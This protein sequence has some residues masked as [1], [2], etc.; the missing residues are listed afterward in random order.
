M[1]LVIGYGNPLRGD[2]AAGWAAARLLEAENLPPHARVMALHQL[3]PDLAEPLSRVP[4]AVFID[5][6]AQLAP[7][8]LR[9]S[10]IQPLKAIPS[11]THH[12]LPST[13]LF[14]AEA[15]YG[16]APEAREFAIGAQD[17][18]H[19]E[20]MSEAVERAVEEAV[21]QLRKML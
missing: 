6:C 8:T 20:G 5:A 21:T 13:L 7:G 2:D 14:L 1:T 18:E 10:M 12:I 9:I 11:G 19:K 4:R 17:F 16:H 15:L 3:T